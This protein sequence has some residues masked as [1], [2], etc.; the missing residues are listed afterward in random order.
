MVLYAD[1]GGDVKDSSGVDTENG[2]FDSE[3]LAVAS[4]L[5]PII[6]SCP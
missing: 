6:M 1:A 5:S 2:G 3:L 4:A